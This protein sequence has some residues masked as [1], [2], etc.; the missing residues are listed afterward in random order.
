M[1]GAVRANSACKLTAGIRLDQL[2][3]VGI[4]RASTQMLDHGRWRENG[5]THGVELDTVKTCQIG[6]RNVAHAVMFGQQ[7]TL[8]G[9]A[10]TRA[11]GRPKLL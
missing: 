2:A 4:E 6:V 10:E 8:D 7:C 1:P 5:G 3:V 9:D 11:D